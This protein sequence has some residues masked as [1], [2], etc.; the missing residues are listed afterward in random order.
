MRVRRLDHI[1]LAM[2][3]G[4]ESDARDFYQG[5]LGIPETIKPAGP[6]PDHPA[7][8]PGYYSKSG[9][10]PPGYFDPPPADS[11]APVLPM[12]SSIVRSFC[13]SRRSTATTVS[14][15]AGGASA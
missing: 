5:I 14:E 4:R 15:S 10:P 6:P 2:P 3:A 1:L 8:P 9:P 7:L 12:T 11:G 13:R